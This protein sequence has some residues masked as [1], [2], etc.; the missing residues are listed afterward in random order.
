[1]RKWIMMIGKVAVVLFFVFMFAMN[2]QTFAQT[3]YLPNVRVDD[4]L[5]DHQNNPSI[6]VDA[7]GNV[8]VAWHDSRNGN[9]DIYF[10]KSTDGGASFGTNLRV[11]DSLSGDQNDPSI[12]VDASG[13]VYV[14]WRDS[15]NGDFD[16]YFAKST[17]G[18]ASFGTN[19]R[20]DD[21]L[22]GGQYDPSIAVD[23]SGNVYVAWRDHRN[24]IDDMYFAK[25]TDGGA[26]FGTNLRVDD[27]LGGGQED[28]SIAV[29]AS[30]DIYVAWQDSRNGDFDIY[31]AKSTDGGA[32]FGTNLGVNDSSGGHQ[33]DPSIAVD[34]IGDIYVAW[35]DSR[36]GDRDIYLA[37]STDG[38]ASFGTNLRVDDSLSGGQWSSS[39]AVDASGNVYVAWHD[40]RNGDFDIYFAKSTDGGASFGTNL[41][42][43]DSLSGKQEYPSIAVD[44]SGNVYVAWQDSRNGDFDIYLAK[45]INES[46]FPIADAGEDQTVAEGQE[47]TLDGTA[48]YDPEDGTVSSYTWA[49]VSGPDVDLSDIY[50]PQPTFI[51]PF[52]IDDSEIVFSLVV[53]DSDSNV[54][55][56]DYVTITVLS[57]DPPVADAGYDTSAGTGEIVILDGSNSYDPDGIITDYEWRTLSNEFRGSGETISVTMPG[58]MEEIIRL[59]VTDDD[60]LSSTDT[61]AIE[62]LDFKDNIQ[63]LQDQIDNIQLIPGPQGEQGPQ[64][65]QGIQGIQGERGLQGIQGVPGV[66][67]AKGDKGDKGD[68]GTTG[69]KGDKGDQ[70]EVGPQ[71]LKGDTGDPGITEE[72]L[73]AIQKTLTENRQLLEQLPQLKKDLEA[74]QP[75]P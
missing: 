6:A 58:T 15:R 30:G 59:K 60:G 68:T 37:K 49:K 61:V 25:S 71:G 29:D 52:V 3:T 1:M 35:H 70:G 5:S 55:S 69:A 62:N 47:V 31:L 44:A 19:L 23:A 39:I 2:G 14:A 40:S 53:E 75:T 41:R 10:A 73:A 64:G 72:E 65:I 57:A 66:D 17:D 26:S 13:N 32:F 63:N 67:G 51:A 54:S 16:I 11:D 12:A 45:G 74:L 27:S 4:S 7:S 28:P 33:C 56:P 9:D 34:A 8:Y 50:A 38:G 21:S 18:G 20:V 42:V 43:D 24:G 46:V 22:G 36:N 48:S